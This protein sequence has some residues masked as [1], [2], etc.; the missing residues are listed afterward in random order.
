M[1]TQALVEHLEAAGDL[2]K[3]EQPEQA[4][5]H[6]LDVYEAGFFDRELGVLLRRVDENLST[7]PPDINEVLKDLQSRSRQ[8]HQERVAE[9]MSNFDFDFS[10]SDFFDDLE[11]E[12]FP[13]SVDEAQP[14]SMIAIEEEL[15]EMPALEEPEAQAGDVPVIDEVSDEEDLFSLDLSFDVE[16][17]EE[18]SQEQ[19]SF[20]LD[21]SFD[22]PPQQEASDEARPDAQAEERDEPPASIELEDLEFEASEPLF[23]DLDSLEHSDSEPELDDSLLS[24]PNLNF[25]SEAAAPPEQKAESEP[26]MAGMPVE[27]YAEESQEEDPPPDWGSSS[28][29]L[30]EDSFEQSP[31]MDF[32]LEQDDEIFGVGDEGLFEASIGEFAREQSD[33]DSEEVM[34]DVNLDMNMDEI[35]FDSED[36]AHDQ[37]EG[38]VSLDGDAVDLDFDDDP[39]SFDVGEGFQ[40]FDS[41]EEEPQEE[42]AQ[43]LAREQDLYSTRE[44]PVY[45]PTILESLSRTSEG[46][47]LD[48]L[49][50]DAEQPSPDL[51]LEDEPDE[52]SVPEVASPEVA[53][54]EVVEDDD[55]EEEGVGTDP[56]IGAFFDSF[57]FPEEGEAPL[58]ED[59]APVNADSEAPSLEGFFD[60]DQTQAP[61]FDMGNGNNE[62]T[63]AAETSSDESLE[64]APVDE[65]VDEALEDNELDGYDEEQDRTLVPSLMAES[66]DLPDETTS[67]KS[68]PASDNDGEEPSSRQ[69]E[70]TPEPAADVGDIDDIFAEDMFASS[71]GQQA[72]DA[73]SSQESAPEPELQEAS[74]QDDLFGDEVEPDAS[75]EERVAESYHQDDDF[76]LDFDL[77]FD[78][79]EERVGEQGSEEPVAASYPQDD[80]FDLDFDLSFDDEEEQPASQTPLQKEPEQEQVSPLQAFQ[81]ELAAELEAEE[82]QLAQQDE[83]APQTYTQDDSFDLDFD[84]TIDEGQMQGGAPSA[85]GSDDLASPPEQGDREEDDIF[86]LSFDAFDDEQERQEEPDGVPD[87]PE[88]IPM[89]DLGG[90][91]DSEV[92]EAH[93]IAAAMEN[94]AGGG[95]DLGFDDLFSQESVAEQDGS[96]SLDDFDLE[97]EEPGS[98]ASEQD[99]PF[100]VAEIDDGAELEGAEQPE[101]PVAESYQQDDGFDLDFDLS[102]GDED[103]LPVSVEKSQPAGK[104]EPEERVAESYHQDDDFDLDFDLSFDDEEERVG[105]QGSEE[106]VAASYPQDDGFDLD[107]DLS[108]DDEEEQPASQTPLQKEPEQEQVSPLQA[109]QDEL[110]AEL[111]AEEEQLAQQDEPAP[112]TYTQDDSFDLDFDLSFGEEGDD[113][114]EPPAPQ[115]ASETVAPERPSWLSPSALDTSEER[116]KDPP[117]LAQVPA[118]DAL[119]EDSLF[120]I[121]HD[122][123]DAPEQ[124]LAEMSMGKL[125]TIQHDAGE[126]LNTPDVADDG[127]SP[128]ANPFVRS[129]A[130]GGKSSPF[131][132]ENRE[133]TAVFD[134]DSGDAH[135]FQSLLEG[136]RGPALEEEPA[137]ESLQVSPWGEDDPN[138]RE[139]QSNPAIEIEAHNRETRANPALTPELIAQSRK[140]AA[141][142]GESTAESPGLFEDED[143]SVA[144]EPSGMP[145]LEDDWFDDEDFAP[146]DAP[147]EPRRS[148][149]HEDQTAVPGVT[150]GG[151]GD[152]DEYG[153]FADGPSAG[154]AKPVPQSGFPFSSKKS[155]SSE[156]KPRRERT[157]TPAPAPV[158]AEEEDEDDIF[159]FDLGF[160]GPQIEEVKPSP[161]P[162]P[163]PEPVR[164]SSPPLVDE[165]SD[166][167]DF[168][169]GLSSPSIRP[170]A[171]AAEHERDAAASSSTSDRFSREKTPAGQVEPNLLEGL[172]SAQPES[173]S[174]AVRGTMFGMPFKPNK[175]QPGANIQPEEAVPDVSEDEFFA[176]AESL[177]AEN[178]T[179]S[180]TKSSYRGEPVMN[181]PPSRPLTGRHEGFDRSSSLSRENPFAHE[182]PTGVRKALVEAEKA[183]NAFGTEESE[184]PA[185]E[186]TPQEKA[187]ALYEDGQFAKARD[188]IVKVIAEGGAP[189]A[190]EMLDS[191]EGELERSHI[192]A[193][194]SLTKTP[195]LDVK[196]SM[197]PQ[198]NLDHRSG[199]LLSQI[200]GFMTFEDILDLSAMSRLETLEVLVDLMDKGIIVAT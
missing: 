160:D 121:L 16:E 117:T 29:E 54:P 177:A 81:D 38:E 146:S 19:D 28:E 55:V 137:A 64:P 72:A 58:D 56:S 83:P 173:P 106:P 114:N 62:S 69:D 186:P 167:F 6:L 18:Q 59:S 14:A 79:E 187:R 98:E 199:F 68:P 45:D 168:D 134:R 99:D 153:M 180:E 161:T 36:D 95:F 159:D 170:A 131:A 39:V 143:W 10:I 129:N 4:L 51:A 142:S 24:F 107:F 185:P 77:S 122:E 26:T 42:P 46:H 188:L 84:L 94:D 30:A 151:D 190:S 40:E 165:E 139:T 92:S 31:S 162:T 108:F 25:E 33:E 101:A 12:A 76:D 22:D 5:M 71:Q 80:G 144:P 124:A 149:I 171:M 52:A 103:S 15:E 23:D 34:I 193:L 150:D 61:W 43:A 111:E 145:G 2:L 178:S 110:A 13:D 166:P 88:S 8:M 115:P 198:L 63:P 112:Q 123:E 75:G 147:H 85:F 90:E 136:S 96:A 60:E 32:E 196:M 47:V 148:S 126:L 195:V 91:D 132:R 44:A 109:F 152:H 37:V 35:D 120:D 49:E 113:A 155:A 20:V 191:V 3:Q 157:P 156:G 141:S 154:G 182:A 89:T 158:Q 67:L 116:P 100:A 66:A 105:E 82:E 164:A 174:D 104:S 70:E 119:D 125:A 9:E 11:E 87:E 169:L 57:S 65:M 97:Y 50:D 140:D 189:W 53:S 200:D 17:S 7:L 74:E 192:D 163:L 176:L 128:G 27:L 93:Q 102:F 130:E 73:F 1:D 78:D 179:A 138:T 86:N 184:P 194:G 127:G 48:S 181:R 21:L 135:L 118:A 175:S 133:A 41:Q 172:L 183:R 197:L